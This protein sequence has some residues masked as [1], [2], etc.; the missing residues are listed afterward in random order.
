[1]PIYHFKVQR[2]GKTYEDHK[3]IF[4]DNLDGAWE[5]ATKAAGEMLKDL[6]GTL[7]PVSGCS[8]EVQDEFYNSIRLLE[9]SIKG[10]Q[11]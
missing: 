7:V 2:S 6:D 3:G 5:E 4:F 1:M 8:I 9:I 10:P 11:R